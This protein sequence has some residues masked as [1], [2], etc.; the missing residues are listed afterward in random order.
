MKWHVQH[1]RCNQRIIGT[2]KEANA[3][4]K[5]GYNK[6]RGKLYLTKDKSS[7]TQMWIEAHETKPGLT[8]VLD[9]FCAKKSIHSWTY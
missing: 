8:I 6:V 7:P 4:D 5:E 2:V 9:N 3:W 1:A